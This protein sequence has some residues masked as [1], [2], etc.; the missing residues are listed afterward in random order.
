MNFNTI[1]STIGGDVV[2]SEHALRNYM[3]NMNPDNTMDQL[4]LQLAMNTHTTLVN[5]D[6]TLIKVIHEALNGIIGNIR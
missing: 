5:L 2:A 1:N 3:A 6:S 4:R